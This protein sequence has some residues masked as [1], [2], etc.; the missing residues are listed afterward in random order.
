MKNKKSLLSRVLFISLALALVFSF[1]LT[2]SA[3]VLTGHHV[4]FRNFN[5]AWGDRLQSPG[6]A[7]R[8]AW[9][10]AAAQWKSKTGSLI[11]CT[12]NANVAGTFELNTIYNPAEQMV[13]YTDITFHPTLHE[14][15]YAFGYINLTYA[16][17][18]S[19]FE[20][21][22]CH[23]LGH[24]FGL[25]HNSGWSIMNISRD[26]SVIYYPQQDDIDGINYIY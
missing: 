19:E 22:A 4:K 25:D 18:T 15:T 6:S 14:L 21:I 11:K 26:R 10:A 3:Y 16:T 12:Y 9:E 13:G 2:S 1:M 24:V 8:S 20:S 17:N 7:G 23:E 5:Y